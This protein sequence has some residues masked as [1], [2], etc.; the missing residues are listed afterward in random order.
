M[1]GAKREEERH[2][3][4]RVGVVGLRNIGNIHARVYA[5]DPLAE[6]VCVCDLLPER[7]EA[8]AERYR[9]RA[10][11]SV[12]QM[13]A[14]EQLD[15]VSVA[16]GGFENGSFH[17]QPVMEAIAAGKSVLCEKPLSNDIG[18]AR[19]MVAAAREAGVRLAA[20][21][22][23]RFTPVAARARQ[24]VD[25]GE[26]GEILFANMYLAI[27]NP[28]ETSPWFHLRALH[29]H[30]LD[31]M[32]FFMGDV[33]RVQAF[34]TRPSHRS[35]WS[36]ASINLQFRSG[37][38]GH[39]TGSYDQ[40]GPQPIERC[41]VGGT[42][43]RF[44]IDNV[45]ESLTFYRAGSTD[46]LLVRNPILGAQAMAGFDDTFRIRIHRFLEQVA[47]GDPPGVIEGSGADG[48]AVQEV[49]EAAI[50]SFQ[51]GRIVDL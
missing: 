22:N 8:A 14:A 35:T 37:A 46:A 50:T 9:V 18:Q 32:R 39:L 17:Y 6:L 28:N 7:A 19:E 27:G 16:T 40:A 41:E 34:L 1:A 11:G 36:T 23:H 51:T 5:A 3:P 20:N 10:Y 13:L 49:I 33:A 47:A 2:L 31:V 44:V 45:Y 30:S 25:E 4:L 12:E 24:L 42:K 38:V 43:G 29:P 26:L 48:L 15:V 21:L